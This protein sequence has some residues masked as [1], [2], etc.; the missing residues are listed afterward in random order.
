MISTSKKHNGFTLID[1]IISM[2]IIA[3][4]SLGIY[5]AYLLLIRQ[6]KDGQ[7]KQTA[8]LVGKQISEE[9]KSAAG[10]DF[11]INNEKQIELPSGL[12]FNASEIVE[13]KTGPKKVFRI[14]STQYYDNNGRLQINENDAKYKAEVTITP[15]ANNS[16]DVVSIDKIENSSAS[17]NCNYYVLSTKFGVEVSEQEPKEANK[18]ESVNVPKIIEIVV[19]EDTNSNYTIKADNEEKQFKV[20]QDDKISGVIYINFKYCNIADATIK[21]S[22]NPAKCSIKQPINLCIIDNNNAKVESEINGIVNKYYRSSNNEELGVLYNI[23]VIVRD[24]RK[25]KENAKL[26]ESSFFQNINITDK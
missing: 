9:I 10:I 19:P 17:N 22:S 1:I 13:N 14:L 23:N 8:T 25:E 24:L 26:F 4:I 11:N 21:V 16:N 3:I 5:N 12:I 2:A 7:V 15:K 20:M 18:I 6:T